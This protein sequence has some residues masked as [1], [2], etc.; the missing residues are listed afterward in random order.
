[1]A[2]SNS[3][4]IPLG[5]GLH[6]LLAGYNSTHFETGKVEGRKSFS[7]CEFCYDFNALR[8][9]HGPDIIVAKSL[10]NCARNRLFVIQNCICFLVGRT[11]LARV[12]RLIACT[13]RS[14]CFLDLGIAK[15]KCWS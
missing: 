13:M 5:F 14:G 15:S 1:M 9:R 10:D 4:K 8:P 7:D 2:G 12:G 3:F 11:D 6:P